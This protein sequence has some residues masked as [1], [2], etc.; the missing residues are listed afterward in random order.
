MLLDAQNKAEQLFAEIERSGMIRAGVREQ[1]LSDEIRDLAAEM[2]GV[3]RHWALLEVHLTDPAR[4]FGG[5]HE[6]LLD[7]R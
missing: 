1:T 4:G 3:S 7:I 5:F 2:F 6:E